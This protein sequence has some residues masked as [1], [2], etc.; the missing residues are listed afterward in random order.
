MTASSILGLD[1]EGRV[2]EGQGEPE[3]SGACIHLGVRRT[4]P[5]AKV[6]TEIRIMSIVTDDIAAADAGGDAHPHPVRHGP[7]L[8]G[9]PEPADDPSEQLQVPRDRVINLKEKLLVLVNYGRSI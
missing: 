9:G 5:G 8:S 6:N 7:G 1:T 4:R 2:M 3:L